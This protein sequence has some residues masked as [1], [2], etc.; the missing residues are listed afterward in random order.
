MSACAIPC[1][2]FW[3]NSIYLLWLTYTRRKS[4]GQTE[5]TQTQPTGLPAMS[6]I[7]PML[8][9]QARIARLSS[10]H[11]LCSLGTIGMI[12]ALKEPVQGLGMSLKAGTF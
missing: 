11:Y 7:N 2:Q 8:G 6:L 9:V 3:D 5:P 10:R 1:A 4:R 12:P